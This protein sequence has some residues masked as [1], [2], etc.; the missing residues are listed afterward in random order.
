MFFL[1]SLAL[2]AGA[3][4]QTADLDG[5]GMAET[6]EL[7]AVARTK[8][9]RARVA[10]TKG[11]VTTRTPWYPAWKLLVADVDGDGRAEILLALARTDRRDGRVRNR[12]Y[13]YGWAGEGLVDRFRGSSFPRP[14]VDFAIEHGAPDGLPRLIL[15]ALD[16]PTRTFRRET[17]RWTHF[18]FM[19]EN[20]EPWSCPRPFPDRP[21]RARAP[22]L[23]E[24]CRAFA[25][26]EDR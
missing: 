20:S 14:F 8:E 2:T 19:R 4:P 3:G 11:A 22:D 7:E 24:T 1:L 25:A 16:V 23:L 26:L 21:D 18:G 6:I 12:L 9:P 17:Y 13:V 10:I 5:D 15:L